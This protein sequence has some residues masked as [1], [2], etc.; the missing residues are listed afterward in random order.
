ME[1]NET[2]LKCVCY[3][4]LKPAAKIIN[5]AMRE[6]SAENKIFRIKPLSFIGILAILQCSHCFSYRT[7]D[8]QLR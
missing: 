2:C 4:N 1:K 6:L 3:L 7:D 5:Q 8:L